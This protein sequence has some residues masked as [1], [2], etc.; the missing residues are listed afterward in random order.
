[1]TT[2]RPLLLLLT[3]LLFR[4]F[5]QWLLFV[6]GPSVNWMSRM[7]SSMASYTRKPTCSPLKGIMSLVTW[8]GGCVVHFMALSKLHG[9]SLNASPL[10]SSMMA[11]SLVTTMLLSLCILPLV[12]AHFFSMSMTCSSWMM[13]LSRLILWS[14]TLVMSSWCMIWVSFVSSLV[15]SPLRHLMISTS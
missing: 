8:L 3:W 5:L 1:M 9:P 15:L 7:P 13:I 6:S 12:V 2:R 11:L 14:T 10:L 4:L